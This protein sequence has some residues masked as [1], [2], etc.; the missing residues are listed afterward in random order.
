VPK[1]KADTAEPGPVGNIKWLDDVARH[2]Y[3]AAEAY[4]SL[5]LDLEAARKVV[6]R[7]RKAPVARRRTN[8][9][10]RAAGL[11]PAPLDDP[12]VMKD[13]VKVIEGKQLS[14]VLVVSGE[15]GADIA[16]GYH[17]VSLVYCLDPLRRDPAQ[18]CLT[19]RCGRAGK[20][21]GSRNATPAG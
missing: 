7:L 2:D 10:L 18:A 13:L 9:I 14:P 5:K 17:R 15:T 20:R 19:I 1:A 12:G 11:T 8:D 21:F 6:K 16:D 4:L 3:D